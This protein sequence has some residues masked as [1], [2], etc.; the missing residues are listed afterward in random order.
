SVGPGIDVTLSWNV[1]NFD[2]LKLNGVEL[3]P[4]LT[5]TVVTPLATTTYTLE[6]TNSSGTASANLTITVVNVPDLLPAN[7]RFVEVVKNSTSNTMLHLSEIEV[8]EFG[9]NANEADADGT[10][11]NGLVQNGTPSTETPPTTTSLAH[12][13]SGSVF[14]GDIE[15]GAD[16]WTTDSGLGVEPRYM[17]DLGVTAAINLV[18]VFGRGDTCCLDRL[19]NFTV[20][21]YADDGGSPGEL[22]S[23]ET[24]GGTAP[25]GNTG[26][27]E[28]SL[29][30]P[31]PG[32]RSFT[33]DRSFIP[34][35][36]PIV[37]SWEVSSSSTS[38]TID[39][40]IGDVTAMTDGSGIGS[41]VVNPG[42]AA[43]TTY[44]LLAV[45]PNG[46]SS[47]QVAV[48]VTNQPLIYSFSGSAGIVAPGTSVS[49]SWS[50]T[51]TTTL[52]LNGTDVT[53]LTGT[54][55][56][57]TV[58]TTYTLTATNANGSTSEDQRIR[59]VL[60]GEPI[61]S[62]FMADNESGLLDEDGLPS[63]WIE[64]RN[65]TETTADLDGYYL[66]DN[67]G[68][69]TKWR[70]P[71]VTLAPNAYLLVFAS[72]KDRAVAG[73]ELHANFS[74]GANGEYLALV[75]PDGTT[76]VTDFSPTYPNQHPDVSFGFD[77]GS[78]LEG[79][80]VTPTPGTANSSGFTEFVA[81]T[82]FSIDRG[83]YSS[84]IS[85]VIS[86]LT[87]GAEIRYTTNGSKPTETTGNVYTGPI[88][89]SQ[90]TV[91]RAAAF[92]SGA[93]PTNVDTHTYIFTADVIAHPNM[94]TSIT[95]DPTYGP[96]MD[97]SLK[98][99]PTISLVFQG[100]I[101]R[102]EKEASVE[103]INF[104]SGHSQVDAGME[105]FGSYATNFA[106][107][108]MRLNFRKLYGPGK[109]DFPIFE[110][111]EYSK[112][113]PAS[114]VDSI[115]LRAGNHDMSARGAYMSNRFTDDT[116]LDM[117]QIAPHGRFVHIY[118]NGLYWGQ[119]HMRERWNASMLSEYFG[120]VKDDY[121]AIN[122]NNSGNEFQTG[123]VF[124]GTGQYWTETQNLVNGA[125]PFASAKGHIDMDNVFNFMMLWVS[126]N[127]ESEFRAAGSVPLGVPFKFFM[128]DADGFL[129]S[130]G[131]TLSHNG[132]LNVMSKLATEG[133][134]DYKMLLADEIHR[135]YFNGGAFTPAKN[136]ARLQARVDET[137]QSF[138]SEAARWN[139]RTPSSWQSYQTNLVNN[140]F[141]GLTNTMINRFTSGGH[142]PSMVAPSFNQHGG[143]VPAGFQLAI[144]APTGMIYYTTDGTDPRLAIADGG[145]GNGSVGSTAI[146]YTSTLPINSTTEVKARVLNSGNWS[147]LNTATFVQDFSSLVVSE[148]MYNPSPATPGEI[149]AGHGDSEDFEYLE[150]LNTGA[151]SLDLSGVQFTAGITFDFSTGSITSL[152]AGARLLIVEDLVAFEYRYGA[153]HPVSGQ[154]IGKLKDEGELL[155]LLDPISAP[156][157]T[158]TYDE[159]VPWPTSAA[160][161]GSSLVLVD[162][163][164]LPDH[165]LAANWAASTVAGGTPGGG[166]VSG[167]TYADFATTHSLTSPNDDP[168]GDELSNFAE[169]MLL[170]HPLQRSPDALPV[171]GT[172]AL[173]FGGGVADFL[174]V[175]FTHNVAATDVTTSAQIS[176]DLIGWNGGVGFTVLFETKYHGDGTATSTYRSETPLSGEVRQFIRA[177]FEIGA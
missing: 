101:E 51:N 97:A 38:V 85:V 98:A 169:F 150:L 61:I 68:L 26:N 14:D 92:K 123:S 177:Q 106:K 50:V 19:E 136:I 80:F 95:Q 111:H 55:V 157:R 79:Y 96:Q 155:T 148:L 110:G 39:N 146:A 135:H 20:N 10:S 41:F 17:I 4:G 23:S 9:V 58:T 131:R 78:L 25:A 168:D 11:S 144:T 175:T 172:K 94:R 56:M 29:G 45:R 158:F 57:P 140:H 118:I 120:G 164:S 81:D 2:T 176:D 7:G 46:N 149:A 156:I 132:P 108:S 35:G 90:T 64:I 36:D 93:I 43:N 75:K 66:T 128:K 76:I 138:I 65:P 82:A 153:G 104:P 152:S 154:Y 100:D 30:I 67:S 13:L 16:V 161:G 69:L 174:T 18:R 31:D 107:R 137:Q 60:P 151:G 102:T 70:F 44:N 12:G 32:V 47:A 126:G 84:P 59:V 33:V 54:T 113:P 5:S 166:E 74:L 28:L 34:Q 109:L 163:N 160:G 27:V 53:G 72:S 112:I 89:I 115:D 147:A 122:A 42:P 24:F 52:E 15:S 134:P 40:G 145:T 119:Y 73:S 63:D 8:F 62:E 165:T 127:S 22:I 87:T 77:E 3:D 117:G 130:T 49:L 162:P 99:V 91:L 103:M 173:P 37:L 141:P 125:N 121:E 71:A 167:Q 124:D 105:R 139:F 21:I 159:I 116:M 142:Y 1:S 86:T 114:Q 83:I 129:R 6:A 170:G 171:L 48:E 88:V 143:G 133:D